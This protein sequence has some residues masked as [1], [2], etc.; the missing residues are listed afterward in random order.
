MID[1]YTWATPNGR[2]AS[3]M[4]EECGLPYAVHPVDITGGAQFAADF[5]AIS[6]NSKIPAIVD[7][8]GPDGLPIS[9]FESGA[10][11]IYLSEKVGRFM[12]TDAR[13]RYEALQWLMFQMGGVGP[14]FGQAHHFLRFA[15]EK[16][17]YAIER[18]KADTARLYKVLDARL[19]KAEYLAGAYSVADIATYPWV[20][21]HEIHETDLAAYPAVKRWFEAISARP[22]VQRGMVVPASPKP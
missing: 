17:P 19:A 6:P 5:V 7:S 18:F 12:P 10:I 9:V 1:L 8:E 4:I 22:A 11:L 16:V 20:A 2:K 13:G 15:K 21:R 14:V 3:V